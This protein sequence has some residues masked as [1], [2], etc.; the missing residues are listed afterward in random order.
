MAAVIV[1]PASITLPL[2]GAKLDEDGV[3]ANPSVAASIQESLTALY[4]AVIL[5][6]TSLNVSF[7][8]R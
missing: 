3:V 2:L 6:N 7:P 5:H 8:L 1:E 4:E